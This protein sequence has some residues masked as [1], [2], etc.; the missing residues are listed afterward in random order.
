MK[1]SLLPKILAL[2]LST[3]LLCSENAPS[4]INGIPP[5]NR[6]T[7]TINN[8]IPENQP[9]EQDWTAK[10][11]Q[12]VKKALVAVGV[13]NDE[14]KDCA[15][16][17]CG[18]SS[19]SH[20]CVQ[21]PRGEEGPRGR[22][23]PEGPAGPKGPTG[24]LGPPGL[25]GPTGPAGL[26]GLNGA[27]GPTGFGVTGPTGPTGPANGPVGPTGPTG[28]SGPT[29]P[30]GAGPTGAIG[31]PGPSGPTGPT[32]VGA[33]GATGPTGP[34]GATGIGV[35]GATGPRGP[36]GPAGIAGAVSASYH[37]AGQSINN[38][39]SGAF[40]YYL[41][42]VDSNQSV[43]QGKAFQPCYFNTTNV[44]GAVRVTGAGSGGGN[45]TLLLQIVDNNFANPTAFTLITVPQQNGVY[46]FDFA[47]VPVTSGRAIAVSESS[48]AFFFSCN[49]EVQIT[50]H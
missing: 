48:S 1:L 29:G 2:L 11:D 4:T 46:T 31:A 39:S 28:P 17:D 49:L 23:G 36:T 6:K 42:Y 32:G 35:Q 14:K 34:T 50:L 24:P 8:G 27:T 5:A 26:N 22:I 21:C 15:N 30:T 9:D 38:P 7:N 45:K 25:R 37:F 43:D 40:F 47:N 3:Q 18:S 13:E 44:T 12:Y 19:T 33:T 16:G 10:F 41:D 20:K